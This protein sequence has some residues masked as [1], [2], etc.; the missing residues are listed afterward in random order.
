MSYICEKPSGSCP[1]CDHYRYDAD[2]GGMAC[3]AKY[4]EEIGTPDGP[5]AAE[6]KNREEL[7][8][9][10]RENPD[11]PVIPMVDTDVVGGDEF[12]CWMAAF[13][14]A[15][16]REFAIDEWYGDGIVRYRD[17]Y[18]A[19]ENLIESIAEVKYD[20]TD[21][22]YEKAKKEAESLWTKAIIV[23]ITTTI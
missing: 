12:G 11:L 1:D 9:L 20:G 10:M 14:K 23:Y 5:E 13:G 22:D 19:E 7:F 6:R 16:I 4:D 3:W 17:D 18:G 2:H 8:R 15:E 21:E